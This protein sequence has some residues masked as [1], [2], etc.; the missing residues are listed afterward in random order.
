MTSLHSLIDNSICF[1]RDPQSKVE[2]TE[3]ITEQGGSQN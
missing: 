1:G 2:N 3:L